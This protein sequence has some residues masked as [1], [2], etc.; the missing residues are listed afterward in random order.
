MKRLFLIMILLL[1][2]VVRA[3]AQ[4][5]IQ[6]LIRQDRPSRYY[7]GKEDE[8]L[9]PVNVLGFVA[10]PGQYLVPSNTDLVSLIAYAGGFIEGARPN[11]VKIVRSYHQ[12]NEPPVLWV[13]MDE[14]FKTADR[15]L[16][17]SLKPDDTIIVG[18]SKGYTFRRVMDFIARLTILAQIYFYISVARRQ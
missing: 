17:P 14:Y 5:E 11:R 8:L 13:D 1:L 6:S 12:S 4:E 9:M 10:K 15:N 18:G 16:L 3:Q 7:I 2:Q